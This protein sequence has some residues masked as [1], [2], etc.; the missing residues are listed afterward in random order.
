MATH[1]HASH[2]KFTK[3]HI[4]SEYEFF[5][6]SPFLRTNVLLA[7]G[8]KSKGYFSYV[9]YSIVDKL[10]LVISKTRGYFVEL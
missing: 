8:K 10:L 5:I 2:A 4:G 3:H 1:E 7:S 9:E 6:L